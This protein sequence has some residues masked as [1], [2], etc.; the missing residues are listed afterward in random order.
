MES[1]CTLSQTGCVQK[2]NL[3]IS[4]LLMVGQLMVQGLM[5]F[6]LMGMT[7][8]IKD[9]V[10]VILENRR[11]NEGQ[12]EKESTWGLFQFQ[13]FELTCNGNLLSKNPMVANNGFLGLMN[14]PG[15]S[16]SIPCFDFSSVDDPCKVYVKRLASGVT[17]E[18]PENTTSVTNGTGN[19]DD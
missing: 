7:E 5:L 2:L 4:Y 15:D 16:N 14:K 11:E 3:Q 1:L 8:M 17:H 13:Q 9:Y 18:F 19:Q 12:L 10:T 6:I